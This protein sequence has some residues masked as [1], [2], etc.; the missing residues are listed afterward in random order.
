VDLFGV[1]PFIYLVPRFIIGG[2]LVPFFFI[3]EGLLLTPRIKLIRWLR[4]KAKWGYS[5]SFQVG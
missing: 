4:L 2:R 3:K 5:S 1:G